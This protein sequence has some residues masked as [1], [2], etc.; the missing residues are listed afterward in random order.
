MT[1]LSKRSLMKVAA[2][3]ALASA[4]LIGCGKKEEVAPAPAPAPAVAEAPKAAPLKIAFAYVGPVGDGG[5]TF[6]HDNGR[7]AVEKEF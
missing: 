4:A 5:W 3:T 2:L 1:D 6:A 7:K